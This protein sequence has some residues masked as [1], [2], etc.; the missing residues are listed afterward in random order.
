MLAK[1]CW[2]TYLTSRGLA[3]GV[4]L[5]LALNLN[6]GNAAECDS[7]DC[8]AHWC[9]CL[10]GWDTDGLHCCNQFPQSWVL[11]FPVKSAMYCLAGAWRACAKQP[12]GDEASSATFLWRKRKGLLNPVVFSGRLRVCRTLA[13]LIKRG[14][15][16]RACERASHKVRMCARSLACN[17]YVQ[18]AAVAPSGLPPEMFPASLLSSEERRS[19]ENHLVMNCSS[20][21]TSDWLAHRQ[22][23]R[24]KKSTST[25]ASYDIT[26]TLMYYS[27]FPLWF[28]KVLD[29]SL[30]Y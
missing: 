8:W 3:G 7:V 16:V 9:C 20:R 26:N 19:N 2:K 22:W 11:F 13:S 27:S 24:V 12:A 17:A 30:R 25:K 14:E 23:P 18:N 5:A 21:R 10:N 6:I 4:I 15:T 1:R 29:D 28:P